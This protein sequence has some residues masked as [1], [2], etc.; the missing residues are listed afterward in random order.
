MNIGPPIISK[1]NIEGEGLFNNQRYEIDKITNT[2][3]KS[4]IG[5]LLEIIERY[6]NS[7]HSSLDD[8]TPNDAISDPKKEDTCHALEYP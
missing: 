7:P 5:I 2:I 6:N 4:L 1:I 8:I 3:I